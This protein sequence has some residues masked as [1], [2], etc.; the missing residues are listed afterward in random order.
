MREIQ[1]RNVHTEPQQ[2]AQCGLGVRGRTNGRDNFRP[3][4][5]GMNTFRPQIERAG[6]IRFALQTGY[7]AGY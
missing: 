6:S 7:L 3:P 5:I 4:R 2:V 1:A